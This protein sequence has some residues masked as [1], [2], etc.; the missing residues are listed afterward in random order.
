MNQ[1]KP[2]LVGMVIEC[3]PFK[4]VSDSTALH[5]R[6]PRLLKIEIIDLFQ[7]IINSNWTAAAWKLEMHRWIIGYGAYLECSWL[8]VQAWVYPTKDY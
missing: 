6:W 2:I 3:F 4:F 7:F 1:L 5:S 8:R